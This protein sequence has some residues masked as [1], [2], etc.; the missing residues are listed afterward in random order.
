MYCT[1]ASI[2]CNVKQTTVGLIPITV[3][4]TH[5]SVRNLNTCEEKAKYTKVNPTKVASSW[6]VLDEG[7]EIS[8]HCH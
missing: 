8:E 1:H 5:C 2:Q 4:T 7:S 6:K 3:P